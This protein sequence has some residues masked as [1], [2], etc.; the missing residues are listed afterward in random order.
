MEIVKLQ[1]STSLLLLVFCIGAF[2]TS[3]ASGPQPS[4]HVSTIEIKLPETLVS[5]YLVPSN[6]PSLDAKE[7]VSNA[8]K[9]RIHGPLGKGISALIS[10][11]LMQVEYRSK[12]ECSEI[13]AQTLAYM[14]AKPDQLSQLKNAKGFVLISTTGLPGWP[15]RHELAGRAAAA[16]LALEQ[17]CI[18]VDM[19][20]PR[21]M[22]P[23]DALETVAIGKEVEFKNWIKVLTSKSETGCW[24]TSRGLARTGL[25]DLQAVEASPQLAEPLPYVMTGLAWKIA[26]KFAIDLSQNPRL[27][28]FALP[29]DIEISELDIS[30]ANWNQ[31][32]R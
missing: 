11:G 32:K 3:C 14:G 13:P 5:M 12:D 26:N 30:E 6:K 18:L 1:R 7:I 29:A 23:Q 22:T 24:M 31:F 17:N 15:P 28:S 25:P 8:V 4:E 16:A 2:L 27:T 9:R 20:F 19:Y 21:V 10:R